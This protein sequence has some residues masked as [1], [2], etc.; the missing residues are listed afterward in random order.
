MLKH[1]PLNEAPFKKSHQQDDAVDSTDQSVPK[2]VGKAKDRSPSRAKVTSYPLLAPETVR[3]RSSFFKN[4]L[5]TQLRRKT[6]LHKRGLRVVSCFSW[7]RCVVCYFNSHPHDV[8]FNFNRLHL[9]RWNRD[10]AAAAAGCWHILDRH[11]VE[12]SSLVWPKRRQ[13]TRSSLFVRDCLNLSDLHFDLRV[14]AAANC[15]IIYQK[16]PFDLWRSELAVWRNLQTWKKVILHVGR[17]RPINCTFSI[18]SEVGGIPAKTT[19]K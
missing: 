17:F 9:S 8:F 11:L 2:I 15:K 10:S 19:A 13:V 5:L 1:E 14:T 6:P 7:C 16:C 3:P 4:T 18:R 12:V